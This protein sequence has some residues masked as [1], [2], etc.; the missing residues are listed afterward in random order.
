MPATQDKGNS[1]T[2]RLLLP[3][4]HPQPGTLTTK[5]T[6]IIPSH[7]AKGD[8]RVRSVLQR[9]EF[10]SPIRGQAISMCRSLQPTPS[11]PFPKQHPRRRACCPGHYPPQQ[12][13][14]ANNKY[15]RLWRPM[16]GWFRRH[17][18]LLDA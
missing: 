18:L 8:S 3:F 14:E 5:L 2:L 7:S 6:I 13:E 1:I 16:K 15:A 9:T 11:L 17:L 4:I 12:E 10:A